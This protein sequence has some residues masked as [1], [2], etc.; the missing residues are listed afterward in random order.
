MPIQSVFGSFKSLK[1]IKS[2][3]ER[4]IKFSDEEW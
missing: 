4:E 3:S 2:S 1:E